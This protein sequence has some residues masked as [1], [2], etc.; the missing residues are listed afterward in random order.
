MPTPDGSAD[1]MLS[2]AGWIGPWL[3]SGDGLSGN[4]L[5]GLAWL[6]VFSGEMAE[7]FWTDDGVSLAG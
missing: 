5:D 2:D 6:T 1:G 4:G 3:G 7:A